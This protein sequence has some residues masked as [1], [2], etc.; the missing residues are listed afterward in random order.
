VH[1]TPPSLSLLR[2]DISP[3]TDSV[4]QKALA[5]RPEERFQTAGEFS[6][7]FA[8]SIHI[9]DQLNQVA[10]QNGIPGMVL[11]GGK[12]ED[13]GAQR[14]LAASK[15][16]VRVKPV[17]KRAPGLPRTIIAV[18]LLLALTMGAAV[19][20]GLITT[21]FT[22]D[23]QKHATPPVNTLVDD[24]SNSG[25]WPTGGAFFFNDQRYHI[26]NKSAHNVALALYA[27]HQYA[28]FRLTVTMTEIQGSSDGAD[29]YGVAFRGTADQSHYYLFEVDAWAGG[30]YQ[31]LRY[32][33]DAHW[34]TLAGGPTSLLLA[35]AGKS[36]TITVVAI[37]H[38]FSFLINGKPVGL[39][40]T[41]SSPTALTTGEVGFSVEEEGTEIIYSHLYLNNS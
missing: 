31:F 40:V 6:S 4:I 9:S 3:N 34:Q 2:A 12:G 35:G 28:N 18:T 30:Q 13:S 23:L 38:T 19:I 10:P 5:K 33:G 26:Q 32:D 15:P 11:D 16:V 17:V 24:L 1:E 20:G 37:G 21:H 36:N 14:V 8:Q 7:A 41:D 39:S 25:D 27:D 22:T 29:Y